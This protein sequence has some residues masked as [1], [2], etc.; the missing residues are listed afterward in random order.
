MMEMETVII[1]VSSGRGPAECERAVALFSEHLVKRLG[2]RI[3]AE[4]PGQR[5]DSKSHVALELS[6][7]NQKAAIQVL[8]AYIG[9]VLWICPSPYRPECK[10]K[11]WFLRVSIGPAGDAP[12]LPV[13]LK[14]S[15]LR[16]ETARSSG[17]GGQN[18]NKTETAVRVVHLP[19]GLSAVARDE[20]SQF[21]NKERALARLQAKLSEIADQAE[22]RARAGIRN[23]HDALERGNAV[24]TFEGLDFIEC[25]GIDKEYL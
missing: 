12:S 10:R 14:P 6:A 11:N 24:A 20:R 16:F 22:A 17:K 18:V 25:P 15:E 3:V 7:G 23:G 4:A 9:T 2:A 19:T 21:R 8:S 1:H 5:R 13:S